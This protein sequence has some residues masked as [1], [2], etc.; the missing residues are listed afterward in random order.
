MFDPMIPPTPCYVVDEQLLKKNLQILDSV[1]RETGCRILLAQKAFS[2]FSVYP[3]IGKYLDGA[4]S[5]SLFEARLAREEMGKEVHIYAPAY[6]ED[7]FE[8]ILKYS[9]HIVFNSFSQWK[10]FR[11]MVR[12]CPRKVSCGIRVNPEYSEIETEIYDPCGKFSRLGVTLPNFH[13]EE[14]CGLEGIH[15]HTLCEQGAETLDRT[16]RVF[17]EKFGRFLSGLQWVNFG[18]GHHITKPGY[19]LPLLKDC[20]CR[21]QERYGVQVYL[22]PGEAVALNA[23]FLISTVLDVTENGIGIAVLDTSAACHMPDVLEMPYRPEIVGA[24]K[25]GELPFTYRLGGPTCLAGDVIGD[26]SFRE[27]LKPGDR[28]VFCD[29]AI[30]SMVKNN[31]F[32][33]IGLPS[34]LLYGESEGFRLVRK[35]DYEDFKTRLS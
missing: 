24:G 5:S 8:E 9:D 6:R 10:K 14:L 1:R 15:F 30:Y 3:L 28:L 11:G 27:P 29:M 12:E 2:M 20:I 34:I 13:P 19:N 16:L 26:Y 7:E 32:N 18:G 31:T 21:I 35:F 17:E 23:G 22:E 33:G 25:A 4:A